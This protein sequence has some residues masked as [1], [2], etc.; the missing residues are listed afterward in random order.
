MNLTAIPVLARSNFYVRS[1]LM[2]QQQ[3]QMILAKTYSS[4]VEEWNCPTCGR[5]LLI[6][7]EPSFKKTV[8]EAGDEFSIHSGGKGGLTI[9]STQI[10]AGHSPG[11]K[12]QPETPVEDARLAPW[13]AW[14]DESGFD[15]LWDE[16]D[17]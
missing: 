13:E 3:H 15:D 7:W 8:I 4:G 17:E 1:K 9:G 14:L 5:R 10:T 2:V 6:G 11:V 12:G 16:D